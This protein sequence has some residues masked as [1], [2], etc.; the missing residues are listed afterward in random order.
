MLRINE[1]DYSYA[2]GLIRAKETKLL[3]DSQYARMLDASSAEEAYKVLTDAGYGLGSGSTHSVFAFEQL[4]ADEMK[5]CFMLLEEIAPKADVI[6]I[7]QKRYDYFNI[8]VLLK[9]EL[10]G[11]TYRRSLPTRG[12]SAAIRSRG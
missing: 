12:P 2:S 11:R 9:A 7:F 6:R 5:K 4:L 3:T 8:K 10:S 1:G